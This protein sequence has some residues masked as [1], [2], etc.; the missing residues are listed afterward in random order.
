MGIKDLA[1]SY[2]LFS[3]L[4]LCCF[5]LALTT[6]GLYGTDLHR[7]N[8]QHKYSDSKW[9]YA[10]VVGSISAVT[11][12]V[13]FVPFILRIAG[14]VVA[15][16]DFILFILW[17]ALFGVFGKMY[18][19]EDAEGDSD[20]QRMKNAVWVDL[21]SALLWLIATLAALGYW[22]KHRDTRSRFTGRAHV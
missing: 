8:Q 22:W 9:V 2:V 17:I 11:C 3:A 20:V 14:V 1:V 5:A 19:S 16:W 12:V 6:C 4:H 13:Y 21:A 7:A 10:V 18:I 15:I